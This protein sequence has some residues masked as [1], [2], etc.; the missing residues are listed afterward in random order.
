[1]LSSG[2][3]IYDPSEVETKFRA[4]LVDLETST[5][6]VWLG[7]TNNAV[8]SLPVILC[9]VVE[10]ETKSTYTTRRYPR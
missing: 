2:Y 3:N 1:M 8:C 6:T 4:Y 7:Y 10:K 5:D 9:L